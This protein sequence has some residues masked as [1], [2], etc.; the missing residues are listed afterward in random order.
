MNLR[1]AAVALNQTPLDWPGN[2]SRIR[3]AL[4]DARDEGASLVCLPELCL[5]G[6]GCEDAFFAP[7]TWERAWQMLV[8]LLPDTRGMVVAFGLP[9]FHQR[10]LFNVSAVA[11]DGKLLGLAAKKNLA[12]DGIHYE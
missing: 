11:A 9:V 1:L 2:E 3:A 5:T 4:K 8:D 7:A 6:Y 12:G 10:A